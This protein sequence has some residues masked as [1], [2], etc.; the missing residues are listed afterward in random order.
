MR[1]YSILFLCGVISIG[2]ATADEI[3]G[4]V[5]RVIDGDTIEVK[6]IPPQLLAYTPGLP[7]RLKNIDAP[8]SMQPFGRWSK[9]MLSSMV[10]GEVVTV[11]FSSTDKYGRILGVVST[12]KSHDVG[13]DMV[14]KGAAWTYEQYNDNPELAPLQRAAR[15]NRDGLWADSNP[16][17]PWE[18]RRLHK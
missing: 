15:E 9:D 14:A 17:P 4:K 18:W 1:H 12:A 6:T 16:T 3:K 13:R 8:E 2:S 10:A 7:V 11:T 5:T